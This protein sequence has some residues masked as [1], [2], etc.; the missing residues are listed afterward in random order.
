MA[1]EQQEYIQTKVTPTLEN[2]VTQVLLERPDNP[3]PFMIRWLAEQTQA[4]ASM[5]QGG[6]AEKLKKEIESLQGEVKDLQKKLSEASASQGADEADL[7]EEE[8]DEDDEEE[9][10]EAAV[11]AMQA[12]YQNK[13]QRS[14]VSAEVYGQWNQKKEFVPPKHEKTQE[15][16]ERIGK[17]LSQSFLFASLEKEDLGIIVDAIVVRSVGAQENIIQE[18]EDGSEMFVIMEGKFECI[19]K[20]NGEDKVVKTCGVGDFFG[21]LALLYNAP[22]AATVQAAEAST[23]LQLDRET[24]NHIVRDGSMKK[25]NQYEEFLKSV[26]VLATLGQ[27][28]RMQLADALRKESV[29]PGTVVVRQGDAGDK[30]FFVESGELSASKKFEDGTEK[31]VMK[32]KAGDYFGELALLKG[33]VRQATVTT[34]T[35]CKLLAMETKT[36]KQLLGSLEAI[37]KRNAEGYSK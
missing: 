35:E 23:V 15:Q 34:S 37:M 32:Y 7:D 36:F 28:E 11:A 29:Q 19:K 9:A 10:D 5:V 30:F 6:E 27:Y 31:E 14:S 24:F 20:I 8:E 4:P 33:N 22:R 16:K 2:L 18:G 26:P 13:G 25:R 17:T 1:A 21:E 12:K 3:V